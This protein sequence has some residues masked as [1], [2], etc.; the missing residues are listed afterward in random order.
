[1]ASASAPLCIGIYHGYELTGSGS[2][3]YTRYVARGL[4]RLG[5]DVHV[6]CRDSQPAKLNFVHSAY[7]WSLGGAGGLTPSCELLFLRDQLDLPARETKGGGSVTVHVLPHGPIRPVYVCDKQ[8][9]GDVRMFVDLTD[10]Q[11]DEYHRVCVAGV[12]AVLDRI[13]IQVVHANHL[14]YQPSVCADACRSKGVPFIIFPHGSSIEYTVHRDERFAERAKAALRACALVISGS[15]EVAQ[16]IENLLEPE[17][18]AALL[19]SLASKTRIVGVGTDTSLFREVGFGKRSAKIANIESFAST[20]GGKTVEQSAEL[21]QLLTNSDAGPEQWT[22]AMRGYKS[23]YN[24]KLPDVA[25]FDQLQRLPWGHRGNVSDAPAILFVGAMTV[26]KGIQTLIV[27]FALMLEQCPNANL[28]IIGSGSFREVLEALVIALTTGNVPLLDFIVANGVTLDKPQIRPDE[29]VEPLRDLQLFLSDPDQKARLLR[30]AR[31]TLSDRV[32]FQGRV[33]HALLSCVFPCA[34]IAVFPSMLTEAYPLVLMESL[35]NG[36][37]PVLPDHSGFSESLRSLREPLGDDFVDSITMPSEDEQRVLGLHKVLTGLVS[38]LDDVRGLTPVLRKLAVE[39]YDWQNRCEALAQTYRE[40]ARQLGDAYRRGL[41][42][43]SSS[44]QQQTGAT[45]Q[46][47][48]EPLS[49]SLPAAA[50]VTV[51]A[52][53]AG[54]FLGPYF[55]RMR[56]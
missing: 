21:T 39:R 15:R 8:R 36:V 53:A 3:E 10:A 43:D 26:G 16:R 44:F 51:V 47:L 56:R 6:L 1:M 30:A 42:S 52:V 32:H 55:Q 9:K 50:V 46:P 17:Q 40:V 4:A 37:V 45:Q 35:A 33:N 19:A 18:D 12:E 23:A 29:E 41:R 48:N 20:F 27:S 49:L 38:S 14:V 5:H 28:I 13:P 24:H 54:I 2:N 34:D 25:F 11:L 31:G 22:A 7:L